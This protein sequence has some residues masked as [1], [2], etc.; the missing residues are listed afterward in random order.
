VSSIYEVPINF[1]KAKI[2]ELL[3]KLFKVK[4][5]HSPDLK[6]WKSLVRLIN[7]DL[8]EVN[9]ALVGKY[10]ELQDA[11]LSVMEAVK[12]AG[13][14]NKAKTNLLWVDSER[15][16]DKKTAKEEYNTLKKAHG[17]IIMGGFGNRGI[18]GKILTAK[19]ARENKVP[20]LGICLGMQIAVIEFARNVLGLKDANSPEFD[21]NSKDQVIHLMETQRGIYKKG[22]TMRLGNYD[23]ALDKKSKA[24]KAYKEEK[25]QERHRHRFEFNPKYKDIMEENGLKIVGTNPQTGLCEIIEIQDHPW[26]VG[27]QFHPEFK[28]RPL[29]A[30]PL[31]RELVKAAIQTASRK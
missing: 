25:I 3:C 2:S 1:E 22:G 20:Y 18:E 15:L 27:V 12:S 21:E 24:F 11:Y 6:K 16:E 17:V 8:P 7:S 10:T 26:F 13:Y 9:I 19:Y 4:E 30:Q 5:K 29:R 31:F 14:A 28:S 23:C